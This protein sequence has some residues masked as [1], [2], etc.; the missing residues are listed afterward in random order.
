MRFK[1]IDVVT[2]PITVQYMERHGSSNVYTHKT[3]EPGKVYEL[4]TDDQTAKNTLLNAESTIVGK[5]EMIDAFDAAGVE[6]RLKKPTCACQKKPFIV[7][8]PVEEVTE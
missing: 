4:D 8:H 3:F 7:F 2:T 1:L 5:R 6:Y